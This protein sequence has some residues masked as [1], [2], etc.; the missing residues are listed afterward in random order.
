MW[1]PK[2]VLMLLGG[3]LVFLSGYGVFSLGRNHPYVK[4]QLQQVLAA[5]TP[6]LPQL[7]VSTLAG[8]LGEELIRRAPQSLDAVMFT[9]SG[10][11]SVEAAIKLARAAQGRP[12]ILYCQRGFHG[13]TMGSLSV[14]GNDEFRAGFGPL[15]PGCEA[16][17]F[18]DLDALRAKRPKR[19]PTVL[20]AEE[21]RRFQGA[22]DGGDGLYRLMARLI[23]GTGLRRQECCQL[24]IHDLDLVL[25]AQLLREA[26]DAV[27]A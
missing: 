1:T 13:L 23:Y 21:V 4:A 12:R 7:G 8:V 26:G 20:S 3:V 18:G 6:S 16:V 15:L 5:D 2:R 10:T 9:N 25:V 11:E 22:V 27:P 17:P 24:R 14:N 19:L